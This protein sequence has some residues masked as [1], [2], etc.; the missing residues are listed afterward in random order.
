M[1]DIIEKRLVQIFG[2][3]AF[4]MATRCLG[5][6]TQ[7][8]CP[9]VTKNCVVSSLAVHD[10]ILKNNKG[11]EVALTEISCPLFFTMAG[12]GL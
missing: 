3:A 4:T 6:V 8:D 9:T 2:R 7:A 5:L 1:V 11:N 10:T 12:A